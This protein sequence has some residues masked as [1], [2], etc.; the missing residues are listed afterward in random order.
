MESY[1]MVLP[2]YTVGENAYEKAPAVCA[3]CGRTAVMIGG[4]KALAAAGGRIE[5]AF[6]N[7]EVSILDRRWYGGEASY[8]NVE[9]LSADETVRRADMILAVGGGKALD[10]CKALGN[11][12]GKSVF[13]FPTIASTCAATTAV[14]IMYRPD[15]SFLAPY[16]FD[17]PP[18]HAF[19]DTAVIAAA[20]KRYMWA[21]MGDTYAKFFESSVSSRGEELCHYHALGV[22]TSRLCVEPVLRHGEQAMADNER[23]VSSYALEQV[24][25]AV[26]VT[27][28]IASN[29]LT[30]EHI[31]D[32]NT[33]L[34]HAVYYALTSYPHIEE[35]HLHGEV[36]AFGV[37]ILL[38]V[39]GDG[40]MF[41]RIYDFNRAVGLPVSLD[42]LELGEDQLGELLPKI[43]AMKDIEH[44][45]YQITETM[46]RQAFEQLEQMKN[47]DEN[48]GK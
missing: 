36:V 35:R 33:G 18:A 6:E 25:L 43:L 46:L 32:Y 2:A 17:K 47:N 14:A 39:D 22:V 38:L 44:N 13:T 27:T 40:E 16:F 19:I 37:L 42:A 10:T 31:I 24:A 9:R 15:G 34:A 7:S 29:L 48:G 3:L 11:Q 45:P 5:A 41:R 23:G 4:E 26:I 1:S 8:E 30:R 12:L 21:G 20:P 28:G